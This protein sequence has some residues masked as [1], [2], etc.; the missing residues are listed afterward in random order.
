MCPLNEGLRNGHALVCYTIQ[1]AQITARILDDMVLNYCFENSMKARARKAHINTPMKKG[2]AG[3]QRMMFA[4]TNLPL[5]F[6][7]KPSIISSKRTAGI[8]HRIS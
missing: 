8:I 7:Q 3:I 2:S 4:S 1:D 6:N 5:D